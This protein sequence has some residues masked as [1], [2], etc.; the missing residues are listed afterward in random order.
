MNAQPQLL[1]TD[2]INPVP[3]AP[4]E[5]APVNQGAPFEQPEPFIDP[6]PRDP[7]RVEPEV[8]PI[9]ER[10]AQLDAREATIQARERRMDEILKNNELGAAKLDDAYIDH[11][12]VAEY[13]VTG[14]DAFDGHPNITPEAERAFASLTLCVFVLRSGAIVTG[15]AIADSPEVYDHNKGMAEAREDAKRKIWMLERYAQRNKL[16]GL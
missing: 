16:M 15:E 2:P 10:N 8:D 5:P 4:F 14:T 3:P 1:A 12:I 7:R 11:Q 13:N 6:L 9:A